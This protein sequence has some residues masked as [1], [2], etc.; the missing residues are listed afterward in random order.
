MSRLINA[1]LLYLLWAL[2]SAMAALP[3]GPAENS[4]GS[5]GPSENS[6][7]GGEIGEI[8]VTAEHRSTNV[9]ETPLAIAAVGGDALQAQQIVDLERLAEQLPNVTFGRN[10]QD[11]RVFIR[12]I[13]L[14]SV[15]PGANP[16]VAVYTEGICNPLSQAALFSLFDPDRIEVLSG[17]QGTLYGRNATAGAINII[18]RDPGRE[19][20]GYGSLIKESASGLLTRTNS[21]SATR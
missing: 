21:R 19:L 10:G 11:A 9:Q 7:R 13:G 18:S 4:E 20:D 15:G 17:P 14:D 5:G 8:V 16:R 6:A 3:Q 2:S 1:M 12:G